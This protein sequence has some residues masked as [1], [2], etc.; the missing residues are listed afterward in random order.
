[1]TT[2]SHSKKAASAVLGFQWE[3]RKGFIPFSSQIRLK[4]GRNF[5]IFFPLFSK[6]K[7]FWRSS[8][9]SQPLSQ[10]RLS[11]SAVGL[12]RCEEQQ[13]PITTTTV[14]CWQ[15]CTSRDSGAPTHEMTDQLESQG[16]VST[17]FSSRSINLQS[18]RSFVPFTKSTDIPLSL[19][20]LLQN[21]GEE[22]QL[23]TFQFSACVLNICYGRCSLLTVLLWSSQI[24]FAMTEALPVGRKEQE[25]CK[26]I[27]WSQIQVS[28][29]WWR[30]FY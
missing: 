12:L 15:Y 7:E 18:G 3:V 1:M 21:E 14:H 16:V 19:F 30:D 13:V 4:W 2:L 9:S 11:P 24:N 17:V 5:Y 8:A 29:Y 10:N 22:F 28:C 27:N 25:Y 23:E 6:N 26:V 20:D